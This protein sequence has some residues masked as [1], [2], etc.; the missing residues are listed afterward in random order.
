MG[1]PYKWPKINEFCHGVI[2]PLWDPAL[3]PKAREFAARQRTLAQQGEVNRFLEPLE[4]FR[5]NDRTKR[6]TKLR[7]VGKED[8]VCLGSK[9]NGGI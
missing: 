7:V 1:S 9:G 6:K 5:E 3:P 2:S 4:P 8:I